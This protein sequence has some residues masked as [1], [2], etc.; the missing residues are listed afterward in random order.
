M[1]CI[2]GTAI[3]I[4]YIELIINV[5]ILSLNLCRSWEFDGL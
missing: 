2:E 4:S 3:S 5:E 1:R